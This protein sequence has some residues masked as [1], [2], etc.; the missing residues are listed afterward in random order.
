MTT[1]LAAMFGLSVQASALYLGVHPAQEAEL[2]SY[3]RNPYYKYYCIAVSPGEIRG[4]APIETLREASR[5][6]P[7]P[8][9]ELV[10]ALQK[11]SRRF[12]PYSACE[13]EANVGLDIRHRATKAKPCLLVALGTVE[14]LSPDRVR[15]LVSTMSAHMAAAEALVEYKHTANGWEQVSRTGLWVA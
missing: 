14:F 5:Q 10:V 12:V 9:P 6:R 2:R 4:P 7:D 11:I 3:A 13:Q 15:F 8:P 1:M